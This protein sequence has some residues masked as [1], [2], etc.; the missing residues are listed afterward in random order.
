M[1]KA[2]REFVAY[3]HTTKDS[4][5]NTEVSYERD[6]KKLAAFLQE[7]QGIS[8][9]EEVTAASLQQYRKQMEKEAYAPST[10]SRK[11]ASMKAFFQY[12]LHCGTLAENP[13][14][15]LKAPKTQKKAPEILSV[16]QVE[17][18][19]QQPDR[20][21]DK[22]MRDSAMLELLYATGIRVSELIGLRMADVNFRMA[23][24]VCT[25]RNKERVI[26]F[27]GTAGQMLESYMKSARSSLMKEGESEW[28][29]VNCQG[30]P[31]S[32]QGFWKILK[33]YARSAGIEGDITPHTLRH[34][35]A[36]H[37][38]E[39]G[40]DLKSVQ[41]MMGHSDI[42]TTQYY[43]NLNVG[44]MRTVYEKAHPRS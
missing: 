10:I 38:I 27:G 17:S 14:E 1:E 22:G 16:D 28:L 42:A 20:K 37:M 15:Q 24:I 7:E 3:L 44:R 13:A 30:H 32:R 4:S 29:F 11:I 6:L 31:M 25:D 21:T 36:V 18:L 34:S 33:G 40:A 5:S 23:Y 43:M 39:N 9:W 35:F 26:P 19:L 41:E 2:V 12:L 8:L